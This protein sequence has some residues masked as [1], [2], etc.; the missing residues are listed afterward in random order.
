MII[1]QIKNLL[2]TT[3]TLTDQQIDGAIF[4]ASDRYMRFRPYTPADWGTNQRAKSWINEYAL[5][6]CRFMIES[7][8]TN[9]VLLPY[10]YSQLAALE[11]E[12][13]KYV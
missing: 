1:D 11:D 4:F 6:Y 10:V 5:A 8:S 9:A 3:N 2:G 12:L 13:A 7:F